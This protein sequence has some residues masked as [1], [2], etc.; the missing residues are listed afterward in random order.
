[1]KKEKTEEEAFLQLAALCANAEHCQYEMLEKMK[2]W[3]LS[4]EAQA[5]VM[6]QLIEERYVDDRRYARAFVKDKIRYNKWGH[7]KV[8]QGLWM[9]RIDKEIQDEVLDE[10]DEKEYLDVLKPLLK[11]KRKSI[12][13]NS[14]Y[15][16]N[17]KLVRFAYGRGFTFEIIRQ[18]LDVSD[19]D[20]D[21]FEDDED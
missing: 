17:Q 13:A 6:A 20:E 8:Q 3:E 4:E 12:K 19:I 11:Q 9:K 5:R 21:E 10:I 2:R 7:R 1:M 15:E 16:L 14:D 18:C